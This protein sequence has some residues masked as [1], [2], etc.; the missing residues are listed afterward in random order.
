MRRLIVLS[1]VVVSLFACKIAWTETDTFIRTGGGTLFTR[2]FNN[3]V[4]GLSHMTEF[5]L[6][7]SPTDNNQIDFWYAKSLI[8]KRFYYRYSTDDNVQEWSAEQQCVFEGTGDVYLTTIVWDANQS[9]YYALGGMGNTDYIYLWRSTNKI[10]FALMNGGNPVLTATIADTNAV[11]HHFYNTGVLLLDN[12]YHVWVDT[13]KHSCEDWGSI[14]THGTLADNGTTMDLES[15]RTAG[16][17]FMGDAPYPVYVPERNVVLIFSCS[18][19]DQITGVNPHLTAPYQYHDAYGQAALPMN[20]FVV[21]ADADWTNPA[22]Y[23]ILNYAIEAPA[24]DPWVSLGDPT[25]IALPAGKNYRMISAINY[26]QG[27]GYL[28]YSQSSFADIY[29]ASVAAT[30][31]AT[32][33]TTA[34]GVTISGCTVR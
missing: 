14:Y 28:E 29:D 15:N 32:P 30:P 2:P 5:T 7:V 4:L 17:V 23:R 33:S 19:Y 6:L 25:I 18:F 8:S 21:A 10:N 16:Q 3:P 31:A 12:T 13:S 34:S 20:L 22:N 26:D 24:V 11:D 1:M 9:A 27:P